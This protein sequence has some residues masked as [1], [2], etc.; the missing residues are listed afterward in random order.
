MSEQYVS[1]ETLVVGSPA[2]PSARFEAGVPRGLRP[3]LVPFAL[4]AG[5]QQVGGA[6]PAALALDEKPGVEEIAEAIRRIMARGRKEDFTTTG[7]VRMNVL[8]N[9]VGYNVNVEDRDAAMALIEPVQ[10]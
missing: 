7:Q 6:A 2:G 5:V 3:S 10:G 4:A 9:E 8:D 1:R